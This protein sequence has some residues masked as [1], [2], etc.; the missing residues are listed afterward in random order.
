MLNHVAVKVA[1][2]TDALVRLRNDT[3]EAEEKLQEAVD[4]SQHQAE[5]TR[6]LR[7]E[8]KQA[9]AKVGLRTIVQ[10]KWAWWEPCRALKGS[11]ILSLELKYNNNNG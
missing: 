1:E 8:L 10:V 7:D 6:Q 11:L 3:R 4:S 5:L 9:K 2:R